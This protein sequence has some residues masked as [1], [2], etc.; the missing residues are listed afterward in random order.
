MAAGALY[1]Q[2]YPCLFTTGIPQPFISSLVSWA[3]VWIAVP[4][5]LLRIHTASSSLFITL[6]D[7]LCI[8]LVVH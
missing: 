2:H 3:Q 5:P 8:C 7:A 6:T 4:S 1:R